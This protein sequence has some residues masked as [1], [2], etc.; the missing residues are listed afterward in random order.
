MVQSL[1]STRCGCA[2]IVMRLIYNLGKVYGS[3][4]DLDHGITVRL[5]GV[6]HAE[7]TYSATSST[8]SDD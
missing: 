3:N 7:P 2:Q 6:L 5:L 1:P 4:M 8:T